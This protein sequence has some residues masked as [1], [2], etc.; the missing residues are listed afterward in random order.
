MG[1]GAVTVSPGATLAGKGT[2]AGT[3]TINTE[4]ILQVGDTLATDRGLTFSGG[5]K[6][7]SGT[8]LRLNDAM[9]ETTYKAGDQIKAFTGTV[10]G[11]FAEIQ[12][13]TPGEG[14]CWDTTRLYSE[15]VLVVANEATGINEN[16]RCKKEEGNGVAYDLQGRRTNQ[17]KGIVIINGKKV[18]K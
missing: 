8:I 15:G 5:L 2:L 18:A 4:G 11:T 6:L 7:S 14:L 16:V 9:M 1:T 3:T 10:T 12:P 13:A 17:Q